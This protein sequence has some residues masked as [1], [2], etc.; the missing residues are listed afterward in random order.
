MGKF[1][2]FLPNGKERSCQMLIKIKTATIVAVLS[3]KIEC[4]YL[5]SESLA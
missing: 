1:N 3:I 4:S 5:K 2:L